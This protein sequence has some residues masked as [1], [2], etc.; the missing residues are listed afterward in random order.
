MLQRSVKDIYVK[1][2]GAEAGGQAQ[3]TAKE[4]VCGSLYVIQLFELCRG[5]QESGIGSRINNVAD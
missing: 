4:T 5:A 2:I 1:E 3:I